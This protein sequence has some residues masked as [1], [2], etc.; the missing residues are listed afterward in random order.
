[1]SRYSKVVRHRAETEA[2]I[3]NPDCLHDWKR[4]AFGLVLDVCFKCWS[5]RKRASPDSGPEKQP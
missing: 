2:R 5:T 1:M 4:D 3:V